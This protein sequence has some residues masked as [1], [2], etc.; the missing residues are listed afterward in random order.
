MLARAVA[1]VSRRFSSVVVGKM[2][3][4][5]SRSA[6]TTLTFFSL[7]L[8]RITSMQATENGENLFLKKKKIIEESRKML[9]MKKK[10]I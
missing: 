7:N 3:S 1:R 6:V 9:Q 10:I 8:A 2:A 4:A 5:A